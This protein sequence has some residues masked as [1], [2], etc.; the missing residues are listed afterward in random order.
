[1]SHTKGRIR[2]L[3]AAMRGGPCAECKL[4]LG[5][6]GYI[7]L[8]EGKDASPRD[9]EGNPVDPDERCRGCGRF[10]WFVIRV[11]HEDAPP[12]VAAAERWP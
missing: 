12:A 7:V 8:A 4:S 10:L 11:V 6:P 5:G 3:E 2:R 9:R 1:M